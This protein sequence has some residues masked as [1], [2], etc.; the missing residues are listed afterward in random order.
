MD[1]FTTEQGVLFYCYAIEAE[2]TEKLSQFLG[3]LESSGIAR[4]IREEMEKQTGGRPPYDPARM[5]ATVLYGFAMGSPTLRQ[6]E[7]SCR[8]DLRFMYLMGGKTPSYASFCNFINKVIKP[9]AEEVFTL[10]TDAIRRKFGLSFDDC[11]IDGTKMEADANKY[12]FV[13]KPTKFHERL[14]DKVRGLLQVMV[15]ERGVPKA[16]FV[17]SSLVAEKL[18]EAKAVLKGLPEEDVGERMAWTKMMDSLSAYLSK[19]LDYEEKERICGP[20]RNSYYKTD[21]DATAM[22]LKEDYYSGLG[23]NMHA[24]YEIQYVVSSELIAS[25]Y[26]SQDRTDIYTL[27]PSI[28]TFHRMYGIYPKRLVADAG[29]GCKTNYRYCSDRS[30]E[31]FIKYQAWEG[32]CSGRAPALYELDLDCNLFCIGGRMGVPGDVEGRHHKREGTVFYTVE[33]CIGCRFMAYCRRFMNESEGG[34]EGI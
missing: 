31:A 16:G 34:L 4:V 18:I 21:H 17:P 27:V 23:S 2:Q 15:L 26:T 8:Y 22:C 5:F 32:E 9:H 11:Y 28:E 19:L 30:I 29:Y 13:W 24:A 10:V 12:K 25:Y 7:E 33:E 3:L 20:G 1:Y 14:S 6:L